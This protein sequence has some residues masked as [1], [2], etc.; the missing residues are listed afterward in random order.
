MSEHKANPAL[1][2]SI[3][4]QK[5]NILGL[6]HGGKIDANKYLMMLKLAIK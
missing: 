4:E 2:S 6:F 3:F 5:I 1:F